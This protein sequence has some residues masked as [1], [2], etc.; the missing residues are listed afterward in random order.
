MPSYMPMFFT[1]SLI[2]LY[3]LITVRKMPVLE[4]EGNLNIYLEIQTVSAAS[5]SDY[6]PVEAGDADLTCHHLTGVDRLFLKSEIVNIRLFLALR[7]LLQL[8]ISPVA[9]R[10][11]S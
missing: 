8:L 10:R 3:V 5:L 9:V 6:N 4:T 7:F 11:Q 1:F 2:F